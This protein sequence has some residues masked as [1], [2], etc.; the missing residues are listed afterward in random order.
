VERAS[1][2]DWLA[3]RLGV[4]TPEVATVVYHSIVLQYLDQPSRDRLHDV[5]ATAGARASADAPLAWLRMEP[6]GEQAEV[7]LTMWPGGAERLVAATSFHGRDVR[8]IA[9]S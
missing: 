3:A 6:G 9:P 7:R 8:P 4:A 2:P 1:A 5:L